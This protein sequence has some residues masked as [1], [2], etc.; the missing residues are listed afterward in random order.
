MYLISVEEPN[1]ALRHSRDMSAFSYISRSGC[2]YLLVLENECSYCFLSQIRKCMINNSKSPPY[3]V[4][5]RHTFHSFTGNYG[6]LLCPTLFLDH[7]YWSH[8]FLATDPKYRRAVFRN[9]IIRK[10]T[11]TL[12]RNDDD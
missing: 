12:H 4:G 10:I 1:S 9:F 7:I 2:C 3:L 8:T 5:L 6:S 11:D